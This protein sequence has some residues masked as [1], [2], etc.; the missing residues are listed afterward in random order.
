MN[1]PLSVDS[2]EFMTEGIRLDA[3]NQLL[4]IVGVIETIDCPNVHF[5]VLIEDDLP[6]RYIAG[7]LSK[8]GLDGRRE[9]TYSSNIYR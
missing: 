5:L 1:Q 9:R 2:H 3:H 7:K 6:K 4:D 8:E